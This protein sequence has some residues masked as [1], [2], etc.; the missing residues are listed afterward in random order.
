MMALCESRKSN[1][2]EQTDKKGPPELQFTV[3]KLSDLEVLSKS[4][5]E[6]VYDGRQVWIFML[7]SLLARSL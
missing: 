7:L 5:T 4:W 2:D 1:T 3:K 6:V